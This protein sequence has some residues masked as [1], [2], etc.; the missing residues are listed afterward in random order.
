MKNE[1]KLTRSF[2]VMFR[3]IDDVLSLNN[4]RFGDIVDRI[5]LV[6]PEI[7]DTT[8]T[9]R[10]SLHID[11]H[12]EIDSE[13]RLRTKLYDDFNFPNVNFPF[14]YNNISEAPVY[15]VYISV[16]PKSQSL[17]FLS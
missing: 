6:V 7:K 1:N 8:F 14:I 13:C 17:W 3:Y 10:S 4:S 15:E 2:S 12:V 11:R 16:D 5:Y 9:A